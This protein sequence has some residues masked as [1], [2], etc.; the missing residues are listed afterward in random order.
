MSFTKYVYGDEHSVHVDILKTH[1][2]AIDA[3][4]AAATDPLSCREAAALELVEAIHEHIRDGVGK[5]VLRVEM[6]RAEW[7]Q[8]G[9]VHLAGG[10]RKQEWFRS[11]TG[12]VIAAIEWEATE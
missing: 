11:P 7:D 6:S 5:A 2:H 8:K 9:G 3:A 1:V 10:W 4:H 12:G